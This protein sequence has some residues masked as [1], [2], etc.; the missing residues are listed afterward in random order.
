MDLENWKGES[1]KLRS[2][3][4]V[5]ALRLM[6]QR[7]NFKLEVEKGKDLYWYNQVC[8]EYEM[9]GS[10]WMVYDEFSEL[11]DEFII[12]LNLDRAGHII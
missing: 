5:V 8:T 3:S 4:P 6:H 9:S 11:V 2:P 10:K 12:E 1:R 7:H